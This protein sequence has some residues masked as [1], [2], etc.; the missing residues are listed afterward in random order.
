[1]A[2]SMTSPRVDAAV[3]AT[4]A[5]QTVAAASAA[6]VK[7]LEGALADST[8]KV[9]TLQ[10]A[11]AD[12]SA[13]VVELKKDAQVNPRKYGPA[14]KEME[15]KLAGLQKD[16]DAA[17]ATH[18]TVAGALMG[19][20]T[21]LGATAQAALDQAK[22]A[23]A[24]AVSGFE[25][26]PFADARHVD[27]VLDAASLPEAKQRELL[28][29]PS[30]Y[31]FKEAL[32]YDVSKVKA[33]M[34]ASDTAAVAALE[35]A[36]DGTAPEN[37]A[38]LLVALKHEI[39]HL[40]GAAMKDP[41]VAKGYL[42]VLDSLEGKERTAV[43]GELSQVL[44]GDVWRTEL[45]RALAPELREG[46]H[47]GDAAELVKQLEAAGKKEESG[48]LRGLI[49][50]QIRPLRKDFEAKSK[51]AEELKRE[52]ALLDSGFG[53]MMDP[54]QRKAAVDA[55]RAQ[56]KA[57][58][59][60]LEASAAKLADA[61][62]LLGGL[63]VDPSKGA[64][65]NY[66]YNGNRAF[67]DEAKALLKILPKLEKTAAGGKAVA[68][69]LEAQKKGEPSWIDGAATLA[70]DSKEL[71]EN[72]AKTVASGIGTM[73][74]AGDV[75]TKDGF[76][77]LLD[78]NAGL[79]GIDRSKIDTLKDA[80]IDATGSV[81]STEKLKQAFKDIDGGAF[82]Q[83]DLAKNSLKVIGL[84]LSMYGVGKGVA[85]WNDASNLQRFK[86]VVEAAKLPV[87]GA[88][89]ALEMMGRKAAVESLGKLAG[90]LNVVTGVLD[91]FSGIDGLREGK[92]GEGAA[93]LMTGAGGVLMG[94]ASVSSSVPGGQLIG[95]TLAV[96]GFVTKLVVSNRKAAAAEEASEKDARIYLEA[97]GVP[98]PLA[99]ALGN[100]RRSDH[101]NAGLAIIGIAPKLNMTK[102]Q[103]FAKLQQ[104]P[105]AQLDRFVKMA[106]DI[107]QRSDG[108]LQDK[109]LGFQS[110]KFRMD[111]PE[112]KEVVWETKGG[113]PSIK[114]YPQSL[115]TAALWTKKLFEANG[116]AL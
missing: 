54:A 36:I 86:T 35:K 67:N 98:K 34:K 48:T 38:R 22:T 18:K 46:R 25:R 6:E 43:L 32:D 94:L 90:G 33:A 100:V 96:A 85:D 3:K 102:E 24:I 84:G 103:L 89:M 72:L 66:S 15:K 49:A 51:R 92:L 40:A 75:T 112:I 111:A 20:R 71:T 57:E 114:Y 78:R 104:L 41:A 93:D 63:S 109:S 12:V 58:F 11:V 87:E 73:A 82:G 64:L 62:K 91:V 1:M 116:I 16:L 45:G 31:T 47:L 70:K 2:L 9:A 83:S 77:R 95:A 10:K 52:L 27:T 61:T 44:K 55:F 5:T 97:G 60:A 107:E 81:E 105:P 13:E 115:E 8:L 30:G 69:A 7:K 76:V 17:Y 4:R 42:G 59:E 80:F 110:G 99:K 23:N 106:L 68:D 113:A 56:H 101:G 74:L 108:T 29:A 53:A 21:R 39:R 28:G 26:A 65:D 50:E 37:R 88:S 14:L 79:L 19:A